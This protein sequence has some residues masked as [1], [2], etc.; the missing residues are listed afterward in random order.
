MIGKKHYDDI[1]IPQQLAEVMEQAQQRAAQT[2]QQRKRRIRYASVIAACIALLFVSAN[3]PSVAR[4]MYPIPVLGSIVKVLQWGEGGAITDGAHVQTQ[5]TDEELRIQFSNEGKELSRVPAYTVEQ[6]EAPHR[7]IFTIQGA[8]YL[9]FGTIQQD[10]QQLPLVKEVYPVMILDDSA[11]RFVVE[12]QNGVEHTITEYQ[13]PASLQLTLRA[14][15]KQVQPHEVFALRTAAMPMSEEMAML[16]EMYPQEDVS[17]IKI[18]PDAFVAVIGNYTT[19]AD[20]EQKL[21]QLTVEATD[22]PTFY[23]DHWM[24]DAKPAAVK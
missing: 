17:F 19:A 24:S 5:V 12:L 4:A 22:E 16:E 21:E 2:H 1:Q 7:L 9:D 18:S 6:K 11:I 23:V 20:A 13:Q 3:I 15:D 14:S 10:L 8:R